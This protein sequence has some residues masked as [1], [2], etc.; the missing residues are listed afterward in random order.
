MGPR[1]VSGTA[2]VQVYDTNNSYLGVF[3]GTDGTRKEFFVPIASATLRLE[4]LG[5]LP[6]EDKN[7]NWY[8][9][10]T[11]CQGTPY[12]MGGR[13]RHIPRTQTFWTTPLGVGTERTFASTQRLDTGGC[14]NSIKTDTLAEVEEWTES[15][16]GISM[17][18]AFPLT[19]QVSQ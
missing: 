17:P 1:G 16:I 18:L 12:G 14:A 4:G 5:D 2:G 7:G 13:L 11:D 8:Y 15:E 3:L 6:S 9:L 10:Q 19:F